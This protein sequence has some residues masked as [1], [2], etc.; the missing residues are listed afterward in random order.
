M[1][2]EITDDAD[3]QI[4]IDNAGTMSSQ[5]MRIWEAYSLPNPG[6]NHETLT[7]SQNV[8]RHFEFDEDLSAENNYG[9]FVGDI[10]P[11]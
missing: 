8:Q 9:W 11:F 3:M 6:N 5:V 7:G 1:L 10:V 2:Q 4:Q